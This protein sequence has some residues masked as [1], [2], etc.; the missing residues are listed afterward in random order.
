MNAA[1][2]FASL[3]LL[4]FPITQWA[5]R[6]VYVVTAYLLGQLIT[7]AIYFVMLLIHPTDD[8]Y[9]LW[10]ELIL[11]VG[12]LL[13]GRGKSIRSLPIAK[14]VSFSVMCG[15]VWLVA[16]AGILVI[17]L[18]VTSL[19]KATP[20]GFWD[21]L[22]MWNLRVAYLAQPTDA[23]RQ[24]FSNDVQHPDYP[25]L[26]SISA[27]RLCAWHGSWD[28][29]LTLWFGFGHAM[30]TLLLIIGLTLHCVGVWAASLLLLLMFGASHWW[31]MAAWQRADHTVGS[32]M[33]LSVVLLWL[34]VQKS[35]E[36]RDTNKALLIL[37]AMMTGACAWAKNEGWP[38]VISVSLLVMFSALRHATKRQILQYALVWIGGLVVVLWMPL[39]VHAMA[40]V[41][42]DLF[43]TPT[44]ST[45]S[46]RLLDWHRTRQIVVQVSQFFYGEYSLWSLIFLG[47]WILSCQPWQNR[48]QSHAAVS[49]LLVVILQILSYLFVYQITPHDLSWHIIT[50]SN[51][52]VLQ[53]W[54]A[55]LLGS[56]L[57]VTPTPVIKKPVSDNWVNE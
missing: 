22:A 18:T 47:M 46:E 4:R 41:S 31:G 53:I 19:S 35:S 24:I 50:S 13:A 48:F 23:W 36:Q 44:E 37:L 12:L 1:L 45:F 40:V 14:P 56:V 10:V 21:A 30:M 7:S 8:C 54:P 43:V 27:A 17:A 26:H 25:L 5:G 20:Y 9:W 15:M 34:F 33:T 6:M 51:R 3:R 29:T 39:L 55:L 38:W 42:N 32:Y 49:V 16:L 57:L 52:L 11:L 28:S 2:G